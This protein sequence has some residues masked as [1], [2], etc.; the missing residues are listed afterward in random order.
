MLLTSS[1]VPPTGKRYT[2]RASWRESKTRDTDFEHAIKLQATARNRLPGGRWWK[3]E[4]LVLRIEPRLLNQL[5]VS[6]REEDVGG[7]I[8]APF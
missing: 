5:G 8:S 4:K 7:V 3:V 2:C 6:G 1:Q